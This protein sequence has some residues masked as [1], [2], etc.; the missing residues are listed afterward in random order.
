MSARRPWLISSVHPAERTFGSRTQG[1]PNG[2]SVNAVEYAGGTGKA[3]PWPIF[4]V[5]RK[6][7]PLIFHRFPQFFQMPPLP[8]TLSLGQLEPHCVNPGGWDTLNH[9]AKPA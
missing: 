1:D 7:G 6:T 9:R 4:R 8:Q 3:R 5:A 2:C